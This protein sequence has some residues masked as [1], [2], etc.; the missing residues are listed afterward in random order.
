MS[1]PTLFD[2]VT[3]EPAQDAARLTGQLD[4]VC[5]LMR[6]GQW[7]TLSE[8]A[9]RVGG[10][11]AGVSAR[12]RDLRK[13]KFGSYEVSRRRIGGGLWAYKVGARNG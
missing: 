8:I 12:L 11:E 2:G 4:R 7:R 5:N 6:D 9:V 1:E 10:S 13:A 3:Y